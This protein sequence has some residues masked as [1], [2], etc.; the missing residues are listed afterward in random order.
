MK[1]NLTLNAPAILG[2]FA[3]IDPYAP[4]SPDYHTGSIGNLDEYADDAECEAIL[5][6][7][8]LDYFSPGDVDAILEN[9]VRKL[10]H[11]GTL[12][13]GGIDMKE[14]ARQLSTN[15]ISMNT[16]NRFLYG[17]QTQPWQTRKATITLPL[18]CDVLRSC[19]LKIVRQSLS[20]CFYTITAERP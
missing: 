19:G 11:G 10:R 3:T 13:V 6:T 14:V 8:V 2:G 12:T 7:D 16:A 9:W 20:N 15:E 5:A 4:P 1:I 18:M 17:D